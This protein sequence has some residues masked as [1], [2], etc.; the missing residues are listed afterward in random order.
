MANDLTGLYPT[1]YNAM[2][3]V[4]REF[5]GLISAVSRDASAQQVAVNQTVRSPVVP[6]MAAAPIT[7]GNIAASG[8]DQTIDYVDIVID[9]Q[10][11]VTF[12]LTGEEERGLGPNNSS[13]AQQRFAQAFRTLGNEIEADL[14]AL[15]VA[16]SRAAGTAG[17]NPF[18]TADDFT[19]LTAAMQILDD[20]GAPV[21]DRHAVLNSAAVAVLLGKQPSMFRVNEAGGDMERRFGQLRPLFNMELHHSGQIKSHI[22]GGMTG[23]DVN[24]AGHYAVGATTIAFDGGTVNSTGAKAG[25]VVTI[26]TDPNK[27]VI[28]TG[29]T[30]TSG[31]I[32][33]NKPGLRVAA[34]H[35][36]EMV[37][38]N[39]YAAN[40]VF[41]RD[42]IQLACRVPAVPTGGDQASDRMIVTDPHTNIS[43]EIAVY[44]QYRQVTFEVAACWGK[45]AIKSD[46]LTLLMG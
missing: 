38:G 6:A 16:A 46:H 41:S 18:G 13:I 43:F 37:I 1:I 31:S 36:T 44:R 32:V 45:Q 19:A 29:S 17:A 28:K 34:A 4:S 3:V 10:R 15:Y 26:G 33:L 39:S 24:E 27:Y 2:N 25:D 7:P 21:T 11:K 12:N 22:K 5:V 14:A 20:N 42:A 40:M 23:F 9:K 30:S 35:E 8:T